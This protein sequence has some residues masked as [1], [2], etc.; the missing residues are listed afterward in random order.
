[1]VVESS[2]GLQ[3]NNL[4]VVAIILEQKKTI[5]FARLQTTA[6]ELK[7]LIAWIRKQAS[8]KTSASLRKAA[9]VWRKTIALLRKRDW[10]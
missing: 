6:W 1:M 10:D 4:M 7:I 3:E 2:L 8:W 5:A 9:W